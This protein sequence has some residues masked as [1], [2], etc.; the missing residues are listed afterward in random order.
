MT[1]YCYETFPNQTIIR[2]CR[3]GYTISELMLQLQTN[4]CGVIVLH[5][6]ADRSDQCLL[7][8]EGRQCNTLV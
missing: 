4:G 8:L 5:E 6:N 2:D 7:G 3:N 1:C